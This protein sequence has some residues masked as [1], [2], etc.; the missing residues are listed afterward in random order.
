MQVTI[1]ERLQE[2]AIRA[3]RLFSAIEGNA[4]PEKIDS[5]LRDKIKLSP[6]YMHLKVYVDDI[7]K[8]V[9]K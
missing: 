4:L 2:L 9:L 7:R 1:G 8:R 6:Q 3:E 5:S